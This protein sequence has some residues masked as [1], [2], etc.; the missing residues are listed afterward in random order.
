M[1]Y[2]KRWNLYFF[3]FFLSVFLAIFIMKDPELIKAIFKKT[4]YTNITDID[5]QKKWTYLMRFTIVFVCIVLALN[6][7]FIIGTYI[8]LAYGSLFTNKQMTLKEIFWK[9]KDED[10][11]INI[12]KTYILTMAFVL[13]IT[14][15]LYLGYTKWFPKYFDNTYYQSTGKK[16]EPSQLQKYIFNYAT[17][18]ICM[19]VFFI[20]LLVIHHFDNNRLQLIY[21]IIFYL[22]YLIMSL[23]I[24]KEVKFGQYK[25][26]AYISILIFLMFFM[27]PILLDLIKLEKNA[28]DIFNTE[29][30]INLI[31]NF[32]LT[33]SQ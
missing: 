32:G 20:L 10:E 1:E 5:P 14:Y 26:I 23:L 25:K 28:K 12:G 24:L 6:I 8:Y 9:Y 2:F 15:I 17:F 11:V 31:F 27:Y 7:G 30:I 18:L 16:P 21:N 19:M 22:L 13:F 33:R 29:F 4:K 3:I